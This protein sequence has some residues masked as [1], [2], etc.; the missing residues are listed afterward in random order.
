MK[1]NTPAHTG[2]RFVGGAFFR[3]RVEDRTD[4]GAAACEGDLAL[5]EGKSVLS[6]PEHQNP[7]GEWTTPR[8]GFALTGI[9]PVYGPCCFVPVLGARPS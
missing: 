5:G 9:W 3:A 8:R 2:P 6:C 4:S 1:R 7:V